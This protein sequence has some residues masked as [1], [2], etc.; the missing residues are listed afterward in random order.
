MD[1]NLLILKCLNY[2]VEN[3]YDKVYLR[4]FSRKIKISLNST[5]RFL[6]LFLKEGLILEE[7]ISNHRYF[8]ANLDSVVFRQIKKTFFVKR[9]VD[10]G[11][12]GALGKIS[13]SVI[14]FGSC[15]KG[16][17]DLKSDIDLV[18]I[19]KNKKEVYEII[20]KFQKKFSQELSPHVFTFSEWKKQKRENKAFYE[21]VVSEG[22][23]LSGE[24]II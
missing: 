4:E 3:P 15:A 12:V 16:T 22:I 19:S 6:D 7:R 2:F 8:K 13:S 9:V 11:L 24:K 21:D 18:V 17:N 20:S 5:Q 14:L 10:S 23:E 1:N